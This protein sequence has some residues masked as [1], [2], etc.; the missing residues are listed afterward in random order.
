MWY[1]GSGVVLDCNDSGSLPPFLLR[2]VVIFVPTSLNIYYWCSL[3][4]FFSVSKTYV[5]L[6]NNFQLHTLGG[7]NKM[8]CV[9][10][11]TYSNFKISTATSDSIE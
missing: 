9:G 1:P 3:R 8:Y 11:K 5:W 7:L 2:I 4:P 10:K 6:R